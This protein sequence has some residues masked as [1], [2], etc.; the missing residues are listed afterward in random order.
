MMHNMLTSVFLNY[1]VRSG[2]LFFIHVILFTEHY[3]EIN[4]SQVFC[5]SARLARHI[6]ISIYQNILQNWTAAQ[7]Y[8]ELS[9]ASNRFEN[10][11]SNFEL[12]GASGTTIRRYLLLLNRHL[13]LSYATILN[14]LSCRLVCAVHMHFG[15]LV[16]SFTF[17]N[18]A[19]NVWK[20]ANRMKESWSERMRLN[21]QQTS[22]MI[23]Y[24]IRS[25][26]F[27][28]DCVRQWR[29]RIH[30]VLSLSLA[31]TS[32]SSVVQHLLLFSTIFLPS[33]Q[34]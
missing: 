12:D 25:N 17:Q 19:E 27:Q 11:Q 21:L 2:R 9:S 34:T 7:T 8:V 20:T 30:T 31:S 16:P 1:N 26:I 14:T 3:F 24:F 15:P 28:C 23:A 6:S 18:C 13:T 4:A 33:L 32:R 10:V 22:D 5:L 29:S